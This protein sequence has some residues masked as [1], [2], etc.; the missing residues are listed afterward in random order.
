M[1]EI[2]LLIP[3]AIIPPFDSL[4]DGNLC[5]DNIAADAW[6]PISSTSAI[7]QRIEIVTIGPR[8]NLIPK[9]NGSGILN[10]FSFAIDDKSN[11]PNNALIADIITIEIICGIFRE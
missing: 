8:S 2:I 11:L 7:K 1:L 10:H 5:S 3:C 9:C 6:S 4:D